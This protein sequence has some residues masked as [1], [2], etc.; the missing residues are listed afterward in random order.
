M[1]NLKEEFNHA[2]VSELLEQTLS[3]VQQECEQT[4]K[5]EWG[6]YLRPAE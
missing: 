3:E 4:N 2:R 6:M 1:K 5:E